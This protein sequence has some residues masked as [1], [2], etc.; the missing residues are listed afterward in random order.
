MPSY[1]WM[2]Y[3]APVIS[4]VII[5]IAYFCGVKHSIIWGISCSFLCCIPLFV[6]ISEQLPLYCSQ[7]PF[8]NRSQQSL[9][10][11][12]NNGNAGKNFEIPFT[13]EPLNGD[14]TV[15]DKSNDLCYKM[16]GIDGP[17]CNL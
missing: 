17:A 4:L 8:C 6:I 12:I 10:N 9:M 16:D 15:S 5:V 2:L 3:I 1:F 13:S 14:N 7:V 11:L